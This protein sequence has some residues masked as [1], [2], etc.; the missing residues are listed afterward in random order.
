MPFILLIIGGILIVT[1]FRNTYGDLA[2]E[3]ETDVPA[4]FPWAL[5]LAAVGALGWVPGLRPV[6]RWLLA[7]VLVVL[8]MKN[9]SAFFSNLKGLGSAPSASTAQ[10]TPASAVVSA[11]TSAT[12]TTAQVAGTSS[13]SSTASTA[14]NINSAVASI[15]TSPYGAMDPT[16][17]LTA[18][19]QG[20][21]GFGGIA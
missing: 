3:L 1:A 7:L 17:F 19:E 10:T 16:T 14:T 20:L 6:S 21:G 11:P 4:F 18:Y 2:T 9:Y 15:V 12:V 13:T 5:A 8:V